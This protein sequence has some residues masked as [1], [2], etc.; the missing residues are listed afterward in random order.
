MSAGL[1]IRITT[2]ATGNGYDQAVHL[3]GLDRP[4]GFVSYE[5]E[6]RAPKKWAARLGDHFPTTEILGRFTS[7][8]EAAFAVAFAAYQAQM[9]AA[10]VSAVG[11]QS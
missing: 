5:R 8:Q 9:R 1:D 11:G 10:L 2:R 3:D 6:Y 7:A 4:V